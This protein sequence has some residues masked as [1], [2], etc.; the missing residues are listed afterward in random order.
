MWQYKNYLNHFFLEIMNCVLNIESDHFANW[1]LGE[2]HKQAQHLI[3][4]KNCMFL[5][6]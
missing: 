1:H 2:I 6:I 4:Y 5:S 3:I